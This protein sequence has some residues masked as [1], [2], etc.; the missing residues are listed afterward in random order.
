MYSFTEENYLK[1]IY[2]LSQ[3]DSATTNAIAVELKTKAA[4][5]TDMLKKLADKKIGT[6]PFFYPMHLQPV[7][8]KMG[9]FKNE[10][11]PVSEEI[12]ENGFYIPSGLAL[13][14]KQIEITID[15]LK[16]IF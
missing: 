11:Y 9:L 5:V 7:F 6:R 10:K 1:A 3:D 8:M 4:S 12:S 14:K 2:K 15:S 13:T 16:N